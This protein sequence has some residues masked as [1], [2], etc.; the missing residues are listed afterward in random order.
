[1]IASKSVR[2]VS[3]AVVALVLALGVRGV[4]NGFGL[5]GDRR[6]GGPAPGE[7]ERTAAV[8]GYVLDGDTVAVTTS[9]G[10][11]V[12]VRFLGIVH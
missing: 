7:L 1:M 5:S 6:E 10:R 9:A 12:R 2:L 11:S 4:V 3:L 8:V